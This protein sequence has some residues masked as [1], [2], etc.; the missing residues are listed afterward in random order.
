MD[1]I[2]TTHATFLI[3]F[4]DTKK[5]LRLYIYKDLRCTDDQNTSRNSGWNFQLG[6][7][8][9][10]SYSIRDI[11]NQ[12][13]F[14]SSNGLLDP[15][16]SGGVLKSQSDSVVAIVIPNGAHHLDLRGSNKADTP[17]VVS[18]RNQEK[19]YIASWLKSP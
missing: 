3:F 6:Y 19:K 10:I 14:F 7:I 15:W 8:N 4:T 16:S 9:A 11:E 12:L 5:K 17:D 13:S 2:L 18:A 1:N